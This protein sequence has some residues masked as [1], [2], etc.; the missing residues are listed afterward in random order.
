M[1]LIPDKGTL[2]MIHT[3]DWRSS[4][5][6]VLVLVLSLSP[7]LAQN[8]LPPG[9]IDGAVNPEGIPDVAAFRHFLGALVDKSAMPVVSPEG[10]SSSPLQPSASQ[11][12]KLL[13][14]GLN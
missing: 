3:E 10:S 14:V 6:P 2:H 9:T 11:R 7:L 13:P 12:R 1:I 8:T 5:A 4:W